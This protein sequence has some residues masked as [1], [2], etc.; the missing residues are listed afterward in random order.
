MILISVS[1]SELY[2]QLYSRMR[3]GILC[4]P[5]VEIEQCKID[6]HHG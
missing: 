5:T 1:F 6:G 4:I 3:T 2:P